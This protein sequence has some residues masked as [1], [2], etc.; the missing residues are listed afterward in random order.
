MRFWLIRHALVAAASLTKLYGNNDV[1]VCETTMAAE[2][3][4]YA[5]LAARLPYPAQFVVTPLSRTARTAAALMQAGYPPVTPMIEPDFMEQNFGSLQG[6][7]IAVFHDRPLASRHPFWPI[8]AAEL[9]PEGESFDEMIARVGAALDRLAEIDHDIIVISHGGAIRAACAYALGLTAHQAL[10][11]AIENL[12][13]TRLEKSGADWRLI[14][15]N[16]QLQT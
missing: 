4:R 11:L 12:S 6:L 3:H 7:P 16:E 13:L 10:C 1:P 15:L 9:P 14:S 8:H 2:Y 5:A